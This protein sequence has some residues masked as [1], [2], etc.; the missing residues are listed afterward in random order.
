MYHYSYMAE[1]SAF[2]NLNSPALTVLSFQWLYTFLTI[3]R[4]VIVLHSSKRPWVWV[5][6]DFPCGLFEVSLLEAVDF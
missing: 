2:N 4:L 6:S 1:R 5:G 3:L